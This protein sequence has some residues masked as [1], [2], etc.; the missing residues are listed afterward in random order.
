MLFIF[1]VSICILNLLIYFKMHYQMSLIPELSD[2][3]SS[4]P[5]TWPRLSFIIPAC[6]EAEYIQEAL[7]KVLQIDYPDYQVIVINDRSQDQTGFVSSPI[8][9]DGQK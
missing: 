4:A 2:Q 1:L 7:S 8:W 9:V 6:N 5:T 3:N